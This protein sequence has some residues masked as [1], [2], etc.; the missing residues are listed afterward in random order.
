[1]EKSPADQPRDGD[2]DR[3]PVA[4]PPDVSE[5]TWRHNRLRFWFG[6]VGTLLTLT[7]VFA[8]I[9]LPLLWSAHRHRA[10]A[11]WDPNASKPVMN[12]L[13]AV[14]RYQFSLDDIDGPIG[15]FTRG[16]STDRDRSGLPPRL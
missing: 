2:A 6:A 16:S 7:I 5:E 12:H 14:L 15:E 4:P 11:E 13:R 8:P 3:A 10:A 1:M 9:G